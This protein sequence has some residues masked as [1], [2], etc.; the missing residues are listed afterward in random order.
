M[1][2]C[3]I[4]EW[5]REQF[6][7]TLSLFS[8]SL[9]LAGSLPDINISLSEHLEL[10]RRGRR[11][12]KEQQE[13]SRKDRRDDNRCALLVDCKRYRAQSRQWTNWIHTYSIEEEEGAKRVHFTVSQCSSVLLS[14]YKRADL[15]IRTGSFLMPLPVKFWLIIYF[16]FCK[17]NLFVWLE[18]SS[19]W[20]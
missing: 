15:F 1:S 6:Q 5:T 17:F 16:Y 8:T 10:S 7:S 9:Q 3:L 20:T 2:K 13:N 14:L 4:V 19:R 12:E 11:Q 18:P